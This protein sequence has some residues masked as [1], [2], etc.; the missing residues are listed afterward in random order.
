MGRAL[1][2]FRILS[3]PPTLP[4][5][6]F[7]F[8]TPPNRATPR[9]FPCPMSMFLSNINSSLGSKGAQKLV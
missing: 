8:S 1:G 7:A 4:M 6:P 9:S 3:Q 5:V 2:A